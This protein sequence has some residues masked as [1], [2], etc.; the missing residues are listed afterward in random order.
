LQ[1]DDSSPASKRFLDEVSMELNTAHRIDTAWIPLID[2]LC[3]TLDAGFILKN[4]FQNDIQLNL[5]RYNAGKYFGR[6]E[7]SKQNY[8]HFKK[9]FH[10]K[11]PLLLIRFSQIV[12]DGNRAV[13][14]FSRHCNYD[15]FPDEGQLVLFYRKN[16]KWKFLGTIGLWHTGGVEL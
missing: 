9:R 15:K 1:D 7:Y 4:K 10:S 6:S 14:Y 8:A 11:L 3:Q 16:S 5:I 2:E 12:S 13:F